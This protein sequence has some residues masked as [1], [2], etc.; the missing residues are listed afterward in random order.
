VR[1]GAPLLAIEAMKMEHIVRAPRDG[2]LDEILVAPGDRVEQGA[3]LL[4][5]VEESG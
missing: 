4:K 1:S 5:L 2:V 3:D